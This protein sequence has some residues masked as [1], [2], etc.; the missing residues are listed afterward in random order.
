MWYTSRYDLSNTFTHFCKS[1]IGSVECLNATVPM[2]FHSGLL[3]SCIY[4]RPIII[5]ILVLLWPSRPL[6]HLSPDP[7]LL[8]FVPGDEAPFRI[9]RG[10]I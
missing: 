7:C 9:V 10:P 1:I 5:M 4:I 6:T 8:A 2:F 3:I